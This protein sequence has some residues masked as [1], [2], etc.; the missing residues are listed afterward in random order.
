M[1]NNFFYIPQAGSL[2]DQQ[3]YTL[4]VPLFRSFMYG[5]I[6][7]VILTKKIAFVMN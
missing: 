5:S 3:A 2:R 6:S 1:G 7:K 4:H